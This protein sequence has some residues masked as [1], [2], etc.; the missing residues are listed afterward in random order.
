MIENYKGWDIELTWQDKSFLEFVSNDN[1]LF[2]NDR[3]WV[4]VNL[5]GHKI[6]G[7]SLKEIRHIIDYPNLHNQKSM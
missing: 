4:G 1:K 2:N 7:S 6:Y 3:K 5:N